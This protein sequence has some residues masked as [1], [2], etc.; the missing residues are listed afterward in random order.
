MKLSEQQTREALEAI[1]QNELAR[2]TRNED[3]AVQ[4]ALAYYNGELPASPLSQAD[5]SDDEEVAAA[6]TLSADVSTDVADMINADLAMLVPMISTDAVVTFEPNGAED[7]P[8]AQMESDAVNA[9]IMEDNPGFIE[10]QEAVKDSLMFSPG[11]LKVEVRNVEEVVIYPL[12]PETPDEQIAALL[13]PQSPDEEREETAGG[14][15]VTTRT[16]EHRVSAVPPENLRFKSGWLG[17]LQEA[18]F[19]AER[20]EYTRS[21]LALLGVPK[22]RLDEVPNQGRT[23]QGT[24]S[25][26]TGTYAADDDALFRDQENIECFESYILF[27]SDGD[28]ISERWKVLTAGEE[29]ILLFEQVQLIPYGL[30]SPFLAS[31][32]ITG[33]SLY[34]HIRPTQDTK[35]TLLRQYINNLKAVNNGKFVYDPAQATEDDILTPRAGGGIRARNPQSSVVPLMIPS[36]GGEILQGLEYQDKMRTERGGAALD[37]MG[38]NSQLASETAF[39]ME[40]QYASRELLVSMFAKNLAETLIRQTWV[41]MH[42]FLRRYSTGPMMVKQSGEWVETDPRSWPRRTRL[43]VNTGQTPGA[44]AALSQALGQHVQL[45]MSAL[46]AGASGQLVDFQTIHNAQSDYLQLMGAQNPERYLIDPASPRALEA[47]Q[48]VAQTQADQQ[49]QEADTIA[50]AKQLEV[51]K[52]K[53]DRDKWEAENAFKYYQAD[54]D[55]EAKGM[56]IGAKIEQAARSGADDDTEGGAQGGPRADGTNDRGARA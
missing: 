41:L 50:Q 2:A 30:G 37:L 4:T 18:P 24:A 9:K 19:F 56:E 43:N 25:A 13:E 42:E 55:A 23:D 21:D 7:I 53:N 38:A 22:A 32:T 17:P 5:Q 29:T 14:I 3:G 34:Q 44:R 47:A 36:V 12:P 54:L 52:L 46:G 6:S 16:R 45:S 49:A 10:I 8:Q 20:I 11:C 40:R 51:H 1:A 35:T 27:D 39:G 33:E 15:K 31:H 28:G 26:R 48:T